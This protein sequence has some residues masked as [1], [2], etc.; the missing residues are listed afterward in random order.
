MIELT[1][2]Q[3]NI[4]LFTYNESAMDSNCIHASIVIIEIPFMPIP[5]IYIILCIIYVNN[6]LYIYIY[7]NKYMCPIVA[8]IQTTLYSMDL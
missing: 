8:D 7:I 3:M 6:N 2:H 4:Y 1:N 5:A